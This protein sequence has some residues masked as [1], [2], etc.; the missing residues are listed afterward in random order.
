MNPFFLKAVLPFLLQ[1]AT[2]APHL[3]ASAATLYADLAHGEGGIAKVQ[4]AIADIGALVG[5]AA[6]AIAAGS[7]SSSSS[8]KQPGELGS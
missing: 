3:V 1:L 8:S 6:P 7:S 2:D 5:V 4:K